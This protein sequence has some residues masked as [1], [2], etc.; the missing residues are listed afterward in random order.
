MAR[1][2]LAG[3]VLALLLGLA[4]GACA[5]RPASPPETLT[6]MAFNIRHGCGRA[7]FGNATE[8]F[9]D[10]CRK[11]L[12]RVAAAIRSAAPDIVALQEVDTGQAP[13]LARALGMRHTYAPHNPDGYGSDWGNA[14]LSRFPIVDRRVTAVGGVTGKNR[15]IVT[16]VLDAGGRRLA[17]ASVHT[18]HQQGDDLALRRILDH[19]AGFSMPVLLVGDFNMVPYDPRLQVIAQAGYADTAAAAPPGRPLGTW[20]HPGHNRIDYVFAP[21][22]FTAVAADLVPPEHHDA[23]D[24]IAY[25]AVLR[26]R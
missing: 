16:A 18:H 3:A 19:A 26:W 21:P 10:A 2:C 12:D 11:H 24:H 23:S 14:V 25:Y 1:R 5:P 13:E 4:L 20:D 7:D 15:S 17:V 22:G 9:F 8:A 6:V